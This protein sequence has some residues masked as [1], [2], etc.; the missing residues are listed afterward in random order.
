MRGHVHLY[1]CGAF[2]FPALAFASAASVRLS[3]WCLFI[4]L[5]FKYQKPRVPAATISVFQKLTPVLNTRAVETRASA[6]PCSR[7]IG[8]IAIGPFHRGEEVDLFPLG[9]PVLA[10]LRALQPFPGGVQK[11][12]AL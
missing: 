12:K 9:R 11:M 8:L 5:T 3:R 7:F 4:T 1:I 6:S 2:P 10:A